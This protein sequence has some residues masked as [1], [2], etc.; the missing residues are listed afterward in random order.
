MRKGRMGECEAPFTLLALYNEQGILIVSPRLKDLL[1]GSFNFG[2]RHSLNSSRYTSTLQYFMYG[3]CSTTF[4]HTHKELTGPR[5][6]GRSYV[7]IDGSGSL[8]ETIPGSQL[9]PCGLR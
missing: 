8:G 2:W 5:E 7:P 9:V 3:P 4:L 6:D 1:I